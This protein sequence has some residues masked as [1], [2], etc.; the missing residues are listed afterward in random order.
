MQESTGPTQVWWRRRVQASS[1]L[2]TLPS[3]FV[4]TDAGAACVC[5]S[6]DRHNVFIMNATLN[7]LLFVRSSVKNISWQH[8]ATQHKH[9]GNRCMVRQP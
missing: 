6:D 5:S 8:G 3:S 1:S 7:A 9:T 4:P 2:Q